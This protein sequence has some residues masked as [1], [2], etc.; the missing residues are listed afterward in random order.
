MNQRPPS[1]LWLEQYF[2]QTI[3][4]TRKLSLKSLDLLRQ[5]KPDTF[6]GRKQEQPKQKDE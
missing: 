4:Q 6:L 2:R 1:R 3:E 5:S